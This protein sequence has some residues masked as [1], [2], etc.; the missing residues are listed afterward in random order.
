MVAAEAG[1]MAGR[2]AVQEQV[3]LAL[4]VMVDLPPLMTPAKGEAERAEQPGKTVRLR[5]RELDK[6][7]TVEACWVGVASHNFV[8]F[9]CLGAN[10]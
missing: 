10:L 8:P 3:D 9:F 5:T 6:G 4:A 1:G 7:E 2:L